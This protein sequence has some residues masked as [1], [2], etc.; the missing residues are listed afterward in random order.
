MVTFPMPIFL[1]QSDIAP[2]RARKQEFYEG[3]TRWKLEGSAAAPE[4]N[5]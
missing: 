1:P 4:R 2:V 3:L 5:G